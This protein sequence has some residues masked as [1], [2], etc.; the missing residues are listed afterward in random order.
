MLIYLSKKY[1]LKINGGLV[2]TVNNKSVHLFDPSE[3]S[4]AINRLSD[5]LDNK[6]V[7]NA[8]KNITDPIRLNDQARNTFI[9]LTGNRKKLTVEIFEKLCTCIQ[10]NNVL[11]YLR[12]DIARIYEFCTNEHIDTNIPILYDNDNIPQ[13]I[14]DN[15][16]YNTYSSINIYYNIAKNNFETTTDKYYQARPMPDTCTKYVFWRYFDTYDNINDGV[17]EYMAGNEPQLNYP[18][19]IKYKAKTKNNIISYFNPDGIIIHHYIHHIINLINNIDKINLDPYYG[20][21]KYI[22]DIIKNNNVNISN[23]NKS[24]MRNPYNDLT[25]YLN[26]Y[27]QHLKGAFIEFD[28]DNTNFHSI[29][30]K[31]HDCNYSYKNLMYNSMIISRLPNMD[32]IRISY[33]GSAIYGKLNNKQQ[34]TSTAIIKLGVLYVLDDYIHNY[35]NY[36]NDNFY[37]L[38]NIR[39]AI[40]V[41]KNVINSIKTNSNNNV[42]I[43]EKNSIN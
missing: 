26:Y 33:D 6:S 28:E 39:P 2:R 25:A 27:A 4:N 7:K 1:K 23:I 20:H 21:Y 43:I 24:N 11:Q 30:N 19:Q 42:T 3:I 15:N 17:N 29:A 10:Q 5:A 32:I 36:Q 35:I 38:Y 8:I 40:E 9:G 14:N 41:I 13:I 16:L 31:D 12:Y 22:E 34:Q 18:F 37:I